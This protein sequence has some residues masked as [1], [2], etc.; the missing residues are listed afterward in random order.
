MHVVPLGSRHVTKMEFDGACK[1]GCQPMVITQQNGLMLPAPLV[2][3][4]MVRHQ[5]NFTM[6]KPE[7]CMLCGVQFSQ[8]ESDKQCP[9]EQRKK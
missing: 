8:A 9:R 1:C 4:K 6:K 3:H 5:W 2:V 7:E